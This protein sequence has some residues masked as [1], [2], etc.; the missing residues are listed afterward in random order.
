VHARQTI[1]EI[2]KFLDIQVNLEA[3]IKKWFSQSSLSTQESTEWSSSGLLH[4]LKDTDVQFL[5]P[6]LL[7]DWACKY[8][9]NNALA[10][11]LQQLYH[12][13]ALLD[14]NTEKYMEAVMYHYEAVLRVAQG[15]QQ[16]TLRSF[17]RT[18]HVNPNLFN[19]F[20][21]VEIPT[22]TSVVVPVSNFMDTKIL[23]SLEGGMIVVS[24]KH[25][26]VGTEYLVPF[27]NAGNILMIAFVQCKFVHQ[28]T[29]WTEIEKKSKQSM[30]SFKKN[31]LYENIDMFRVVYTNVDQNTILKSTY[32]DGIYY[33]ETDL[34]NFTNKLGILRLHTQK[35]GDVLNQ[36][37]PI[38]K[39][40]SSD[41]TTSK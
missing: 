37:Y 24:D 41:L 30:E 36:R 19:D 38:L 28:S 18:E 27:R 25:S 20:V 29:N 4:T 16:F 32:N 3:T 7:Q 21:T 23:N 35:L 11:H 5:F 39:R 22:T 9:S 10:Y 13:D 6:L 40:A 2:S 34:F 1:I 31:K 8:C 12:Y 14:Q 15:S 33:T 17:Y 26:E